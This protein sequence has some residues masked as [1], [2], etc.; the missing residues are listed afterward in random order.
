MGIQVKTRYGSLDRVRWEISPEEVNKNAVLVCLFSEEEFDDRQAG[1][2]LIMAGFI[3]TSMIEVGNS[4][5]LLKIDELLY[6]GGLRCYLERLKYLEFECLR[7]QE[8]KFK[9][10][11]TEEVLTSGLANNKPIK[12]NFIGS[13]TDEVQGQKNQPSNPKQ[14]Y[15]TTLKPNLKQI[16]DKPVKRQAVSKVSDDGCPF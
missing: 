16:K 6:I 14:E 2:N 11:K 1:Y 3:P 12:R 9:K 10:H 13:E 8:S 7:P 5:V 15:Q 4:K